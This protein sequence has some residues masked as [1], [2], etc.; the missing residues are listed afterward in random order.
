MICKNMLLVAAVFAHLFFI[1]QAVLGQEQITVLR[2]ATLIDVA[3]SRRLQNSSVVMQNGRIRAIGNADQINIPNDAKVI[4]LLGKFLIPGLIDS[5]VHYRDWSGEIFLANGI[6]SVLDQGNPTEW[7]L[8]LKEAQQ[9]GKLR[10][11]RLF[12]TGNPLQGGIRDTYFAQFGYLDSWASGVV[13][14]LAPSAREIKYADS[15]AARFYTTYLE[16]GESARMEVRRLAQRGVDAIKVYHKLPPAVLKAIVEEAHRNKLHVVGHWLDAWQIAE[17]GMDFIEH[18][19]PVAIATVTDK[20]KLQQLKEGKLLDPH[21]YM[22]PRAFPA[23]VSTLVKKRIFFNPTLSATWRGVGPRRKQYRAEFEKFF[24][25]AG[26]TYVP[27]A[28]LKHHIDAYDLFDRISPSDAALLQAGYRNIVHIVKAFVDA[29]GRVLAG[30]DPSVTGIPGLGIHQ[31]MELLVDAGV[32]RGEALKA[33][34]LYAAELLHKEKVLGTV[35]V[36]KMADLVVL[37]ADP[38]VDISNTRK[39]DMVFL[40]GERVDTSFYPD[41]NIPIPRPVADGSIEGALDLSIS[42]IIPNVAVE[43]DPDLKIE[44]VGHFFPASKVKFNGVFIPSSFESPARL[45]AVIA[46]T[47]LKNV[48]TYSLQVEES[49]HDLVIQSN[50]VFLMVKYR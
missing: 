32:S 16:K 33:S 35:E 41:Y 28:Y 9:K 40:G 10:S 20:Q 8:A 18:T 17:L 29:G 25:Q 12:V 44:L 46:S 49:W 47:M 45:K 3:S 50:Q 13:L 48:G 43:G 6:T 7:M 42:N 38:L 23:L 24:D 4:E 27:Q 1:G 36:G 30:S 22:D 34:T 5:H 26:L 19:A 37:G 14:D 2:G 31:E 21:S 11:P 15:A 39:I